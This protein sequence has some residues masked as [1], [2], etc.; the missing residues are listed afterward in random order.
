MLQVAFADK[1]KRTRTSSVTAFLNITCYLHKFLRMVYITNNIILRNGFDCGPYCSEKLIRKS[2]LELPH[3]MLYFR[4]CLLNRIQLRRV[5]RQIDVVHFVV[6]EKLGHDLG[7]VHGMVVH[8]QNLASRQEL[9][10]VDLQIAHK[11]F[12]GQ[13]SRI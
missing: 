11:P 8:D 2:R 12:G 9:K 5:A 3:R 10:D 4:E 1:D 6:F 13:A 7:A